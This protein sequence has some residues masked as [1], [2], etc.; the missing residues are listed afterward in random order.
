MGQAMH[1][2]FS[3]EKNKK[4][5]SHLADQEIRHLETVLNAIRMA[6]ANGQ[7]LHAGYWAAR[8]NTIA[9]TYLLL[10]S[11]QTRVTALIRAFEAHALAARAGALAQKTSPD[12]I[13]A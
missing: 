6:Q 5:T 3:V 9:H 13:A 12:L 11:Q 1:A 2:L 8:A 4:R 7:G 10:A